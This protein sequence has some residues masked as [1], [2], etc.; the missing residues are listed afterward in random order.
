M[1]FGD[2]ED[3]KEEYENAKEYLRDKFDEDPE[4]TESDTKLVLK[5]IEDASGIVIP[6]DED[7][8]P[9]VGT[10][11]RASRELR[12]EEGYEDLASDEVTEE[13]DD[14]E[15]SMRDDFASKPVDDHDDLEVQKL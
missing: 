5:I 9:A 15:E 2:G 7:D 12:R 11:T 1:G 8:I 14:K 10:I 6:V 3:W 13:R 4:L